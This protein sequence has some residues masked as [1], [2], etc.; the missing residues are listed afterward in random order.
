[1]RCCASQHRCCAWPCFAFAWP[2]CAL[3][4]PRYSLPHYAFTLL[5]HALPVRY[6]VLR[7]VTFPL[8]CLTVLCF[9]STLR[10]SALPMHNTASLCLYFAVAIQCFAATR[11]A[12][13]MR[14]SARLR[15]TNARLRRSVP[16]LGLARLCRRVAPQCFAFATH[17]ETWL[18]RCSSP[19]CLTLLMLCFTA[20]RFAA[21]C[22]ANA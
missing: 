5:C 2:S 21:L 7:C 3:P 14:F 12:P 4:L 9:C 15:S 22:G 11:L 10:S 16:M 6:V 19:L 20:P 13:P 1:M 8:L 17:A 18:C